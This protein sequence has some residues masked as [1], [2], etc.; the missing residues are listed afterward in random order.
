MTKQLKQR[1]RQKKTN[2]AILNTLNKLTQIMIEN[3]A[4]T[5]KLNEKDNKKDNTAAKI[6]NRDDDM[7]MDPV[8]QFQGMTNAGKSAQ[9]ISGLS[10]N[11]TQDLDKIQGIETKDKETKQK[12]NKKNQS[13]IRK[14]VNNGEKIVKNEK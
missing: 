8:A 5:K 1:T 9:R 12:N 11:L 2:E 3:N 6:V 14:H 10:R 13:S 7:E 4:N